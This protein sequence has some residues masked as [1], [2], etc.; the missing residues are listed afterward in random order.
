VE[1]PALERWLDAYGRAWETMD[2]DAAIALFTEDASYQETPYDDPMRGSDQIR[3]YWAGVPEAQR[4]IRFEHEILAV[5]GNRGIAHW[6]ASFTRVPSGADVTLDGIF[7]LDFDPDGRCE[8]LRE[9]WRLR[10]E[11][12]ATD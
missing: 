5:V 7:V 4:D 3:A 10:E 2:P 11:L 9:W 12:P 6:Q 1:H 8:T